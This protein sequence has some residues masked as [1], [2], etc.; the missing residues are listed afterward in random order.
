[1]TS[2]DGATTKLNDHNLWKSE[3]PDGIGD[4]RAVL[5]DTLGDLTLRQAEVLDQ[6]LIGQGRLEGIKILSLNVLHQSKQQLAALEVSDAG[7]V[8][9]VASERLRARLCG[10]RDSTDVRGDAAFKSSDH[11]TVLTRAAKSGPI[12]V[13]QYELT[14]Q[15]GVPANKFAYTLATLE[16]DKCIR[17][18]VVYKLG[19]DAASGAPAAEDST[20]AGSASGSAAAAGS[21]TAAAAAAAPEDDGGGGDGGGSGGGSGGDGSGQSCRS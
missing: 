3:E 7:D 17:R 5:T 19:Q 12:G 11:E 6:A 15:V 18:Q 14:K 16:N 13:L 8:C 20:G 21:A 4:S 9:I 10:C 2:T 1:M